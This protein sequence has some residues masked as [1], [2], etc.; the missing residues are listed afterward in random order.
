MTQAFVVGATGEV[1]KC[2]LAQLM[3]SN[4]YEKV[5]VLSRRPVEY[6]GPR[7]EALVPIMSIN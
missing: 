3:A 1:G 5:L 6:T 4:E 7:P 2:I